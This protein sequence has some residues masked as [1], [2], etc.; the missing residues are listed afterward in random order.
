MDIRARL[1]DGLDLRHLTGAEIGAL[2]HPVVTKDQGSVTYIDHCTTEALRQRYANDPNVDVS[3]IVQ[4][5]AVWGDKSLRECVNGPLDYVIA[6]HV[7]EH[8][9]DLITWLHEIRSVLS[10][11]GEVRL[12]IPDRRFTFDY[13]RRETRLCDVLDAY[14]RRARAPL[15]LAILDLVTN[16]VAVDAA[17]AWRGLDVSKLRHIH[18][19]KDAISIARDALE[20]G[21]YHDVHC[22][23]FTPRSFASLFAEMAEEGLHDFRCESFQDTPQSDIQFFVSIRPSTDRPQI[24]A[25]WR[26]MHDR[27]AADPVQKPRAP[28]TAG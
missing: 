8:V 3:K 13:L 11:E 23:V 15:P 2:D 9:P 16:A 7:L 26:A 21:T 24:V 1:T 27:A 20:N 17:E 10:D 22:W 25:S 18:S 28:N 14:I 12:A 5:D 19:T 4:I 6:S